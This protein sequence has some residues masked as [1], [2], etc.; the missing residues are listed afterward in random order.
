M[1][2]GQKGRI[3]NGSDRNRI[4]SEL[5]LRTKHTTGNVGLTG[6]LIEAIKK[7]ETNETR[8]GEDL[9]DSKLRQEDQDLTAIVAY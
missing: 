2:A 7:D 8:D 6:R 3:W 5:S 1:T 4:V 9:N